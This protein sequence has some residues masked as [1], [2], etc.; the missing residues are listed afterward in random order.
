MSTNAELLD[1][2]LNA[3]KEILSGGQDFTH[4]GRRLTMADLRWVQAERLRLQRLV[5]AEQGISGGGFKVATFA[6][7]DCSQ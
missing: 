5:D 6:S 1:Y 3:E 4:N 2:Y 7:R